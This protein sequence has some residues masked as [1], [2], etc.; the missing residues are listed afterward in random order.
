MKLDLNKNITFSKKKDAYPSK[1]TINLYFK[2]DRT[3]RPST[4]A[5][6]VL[7]IGVVALLLVKLLVLDMSAEMVEK[8]ET[9]DSKQAHLNAQLEL[10]QEYDEVSSQYSR[11][12]SSYL[13]E[14]E[15][16]WNRMDVLDMLGKTIYNH[17]DVRSVSISGNMIFADIVG[18]DLEETAELV[19]MIE[20]YAMVDHVVVNT[21]TLSGEHTIRMEISLT[22][23]NADTTG[24]EQ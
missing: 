5:L 6:Y 3:T 17:G 4:I 7:F 13:R 9:L 22:D 11:Y 19:G 15:I 12:S 8:Q 14:D 20:S 10:L 16:I 2:E 24:G 18:P 23:L 21:V 1:K